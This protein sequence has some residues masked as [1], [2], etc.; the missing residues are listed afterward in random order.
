MTSQPVIAFIG[1]GHMGGYMAANLVKAG[2]TVH[3]FDLAEP[4]LDAARANGVQIAASG[5]DAA[6]Q[7]NIVLTMLPAG[8][9]VLGA[10]TGRG[11]G[12]GLLAAAAPGTL[13][14]DCS[15]VEVAHAQ[16]A[17]E[18]ARQAGFR[19]V[20]APVS[21]GMV[22]AE[23]GTLTF[24]VGGA[25]ADVEEVRPVLEA[26][27]KKIVH[28]GGNSTGQAAK[29]CNNML[30]GISMVGA[31]EAF[32]LGQRMG[33]DASVLYD[34]ISTSSGSCW[35]VNVNCPAPGTLPT[36]PSANN[37]EPGFA[38]ALMSKDL[39]LATAALDDAGLDGKLG[40]LTA[41]I[42]GALVEE[43][44]GGK[45]FSDIYNVIQEGGK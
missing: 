12:G 28:C 43:G 41:A 29:I 24:M 26:M 7:A 22:G 17:A 32:A 40:K 38:T 16:Q 4:A 21:G 11:E 44:R 18:L 23:A 6:A 33:V 25:D 2:Y 42:Y 13:F 35:A 5:E 15:T 37:Y 10:Y 27:G 30:L 39:G 9:H 1:L 45:D 31:A 3:G 8:Q 19:A 20:D 34:V 36:A 14:L